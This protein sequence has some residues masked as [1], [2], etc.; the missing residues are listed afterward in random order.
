MARAVPAADIL[1]PNRFELAR[2]T[3]LPCTTRAETLAAIAALRARMRQNG[4]RLV[5]L[6]SLITPETP[7]DTIGLLAAGDE[8]AFLLD[9]PLIPIAVNGAGDAIAA[10]FL[11][12]VLAGAG[13]AGALERAASSV[14]GVLETTRAMGARELQIIAARS[15]FAAPRRMFRSTR[16]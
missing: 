11:Y 6:T 5:L 14:H 4:P 7:P 12:H 1:T 9:T 13:I 10:L 2:L 8:G 16:L 3:G 15:E